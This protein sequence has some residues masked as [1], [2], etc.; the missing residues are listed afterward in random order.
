MVTAEKIKETV[1]KVVNERY[2]MAAADALNSSGSESETEMLE[3]AQVHSDVL[4]FLQ[5]GH[6]S[7]AY[8]TIKARTLDHRI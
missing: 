1:I 7:S 2:L 5:K 3:W 4:R 8:T 6:A